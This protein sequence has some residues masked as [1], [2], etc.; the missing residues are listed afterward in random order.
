MLVGENDNKLGVCYI[1][2]YVDDC[3][4][5]GTTAALYD[6]TESLK[7]KTTNAEA[8]T[9]SM[10][11]GTSDYWSREVI[12]GCGRKSAWLG[13]PH[14]LQNRR[15]KFGGLVQGQQTYKTPGTPRINI[16]CLKQEENRVDAAEHALYRSRIG[17]LLYL[18][19][20]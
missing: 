1:G 7:K 10:E 2:I 9:L 11:D 14:L 13:Q 18:M 5:V 6:L 3:C 17:M 4:Y 15:D 8:F 12:F 20:H 19:R 16:H